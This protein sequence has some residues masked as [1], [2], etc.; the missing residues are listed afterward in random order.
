MRR[1]FYKST[2][3]FYVT[4]YDFC[5][6]TE[7]VIFIRPLDS[8]FWVYR[9]SLQR[10]NRYLILAQ[11]EPVCSQLPASA[12]VFSCSYILHVKLAKSKHCMSHITF[13]DFSCVFQLMMSL[14]AVPGRTSRLR[15][16]FKNHEKSS[17][18]AQIWSL[19]MIF[20]TK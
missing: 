12:I 14:S 1:H 4:N 20:L 19:L 7:M 16:R 5:E 15:V 10:C 18:L 9:F 3:K 6:V 13:N 11:L 2:P 17:T 8:C